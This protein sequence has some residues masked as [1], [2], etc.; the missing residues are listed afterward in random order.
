MPATKRTFTRGLAASLV[1]GMLLGF[2][3]LASPATP[4]L[5]FDPHFRL[6]WPVGKGYPI[7]NLSYGY[8]QGD[9]FDYASPLYKD[10]Y[11]IDFGLD[12]MQD[13]AAV[14]GGYATT[15]VGDPGF[16][17]YVEIDHGNGFTTIYAHLTAFLIGN[18]RVVQG[19]VIAKSG[20]TGA[21]FGAH[22]H[23]SARFTD[24]SGV[25]RGYM[26]EPMSGYTGFGR[27]GIGRGTSPNYV[28]GPVVSNS[29]KNGDGW[30]YPFMSDGGGPWQRTAGSNYA[31]YCCGP[32]GNNYLEMN[33]GAPHPAALWQDF[34]AYDSQWGNYTAASP[35]V[36]PPD[37]WTMQAR[38][39]TNC[40]S[41]TGTLAVWAIN[42]PPQE[43]GFTP[44]VANGTWKFFTATTNFVSTGHSRLRAIFYMDTPGCNYDFDN[45]TLRRNY[46]NNSSFEQ[47]TSN[48]MQRSPLTCASYWAVYANG[49]AQDDSA[50]LEANRGTCPGTGSDVSFYQDVQA[51]T[52]QG[53]KYY[54][55]VRVRR[56]GTSAGS[57]NFH[58]WALWSPL[59][60]V[61][62]QTV[63]VPADGNWHDYQFVG[64]VPQSGNSILRA[65]IYLNDGGNYDFDGLQ[66]WGGAGEP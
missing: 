50:F 40:A 15:H 55:R 57:L 39:R 11:A 42:G 37:T 25:K 32:D 45:I 43:V 9:H 46:I 29:I 10:Y 30:A 34:P 2:E 51:Y 61:I 21:C 1:L 26:P 8:A 36:N 22:L 7:L 19:Q 63:S 3:L 49:A 6:P 5:A 38:I 23:F 58:L 31:A 12:P 27:Y 52:R 59:A 65:E 35:F 28:N 60:A 16:G 18:G 13:V 44:V 48:W 20:C 41:A 64:N 56:P 24:A 14:Q 54:F 4:A 53:D 17:N 66:L 62:N 47:G 33:T